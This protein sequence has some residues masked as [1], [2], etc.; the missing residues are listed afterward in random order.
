MARCPTCDFPLPSDLERLGARCNNCRNPLY[1]PAGRWTRPAQPDEGACV[2][3]PDCE[4]VGACQR[5]GATVCETCRSPWRGQI[6]C[7]TCVERAYANGEADSGHGR[8]L[9][10]LALAA[11]LFGC[12]AWLLSGLFYYSIRNADAQPSLGILLLQPILG[13]GS[14]L[15]ALFGVGLGAAALRSR[16]EHMPLA[17]VGL[18]LCGLLLGALLGLFTFTLWQV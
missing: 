16:G 13:L 17:T 1:E 11:L 3:H 6:F 15:M 14:G 8:I 7:L 4:A 2:A 9:T 18:V 5:C 12:L 10:R